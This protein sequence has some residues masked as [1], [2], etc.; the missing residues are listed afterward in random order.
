MIFHVVCGIVSW[1]QVS[2][3][4]VTIHAFERQTDSLQYRALHYMQ[5][6]GNNSTNNK[7]LGMKYQWA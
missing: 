4:F 6:H 5:S 7:P 3:A 1:A 2:F